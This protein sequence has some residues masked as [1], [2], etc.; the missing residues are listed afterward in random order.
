MKQPAEKQFG[1]EDE[2]DKTKIKSWNYLRKS[3][4]NWI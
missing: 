4:G 1:F 2:T 3:N